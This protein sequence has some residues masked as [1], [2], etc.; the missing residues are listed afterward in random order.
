[1]GWFPVPIGYS[2][3]SDM[4]GK[5]HGQKI[6]IYITLCLGRHCSPSLFSP[7]QLSCSLV[8]DPSW[9]H[10][11]QHARPPCPSPTPGVYPN[12]CPSSRWCHP[13][14]SSSVVLFSSYSLSFPLLIDIFHLSF[15][16]HHQFLRLFH[17]DYLTE[18]KAL[19]WRRQG[20]QHPVTSG[21][22]FS[23]N[24]MTCWSKLLK[25]KQLFEINERLFLEWWSD[26]LHKRLPNETTINRKEKSLKILI[27]L[28]TDLKTFIY[29]CTWISTFIF[30]E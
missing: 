2:E 16:N 27:S 25:F 6:G 26:E 29:K 14:I 19:A 13:T 10:R 9:P 7:V 11:L 21:S 4:N 12:S 8:S 1:M 22:F 30:N 28:G 3:F 5:P 17:T 15:Q 24:C 20:R 23:I 18:Q